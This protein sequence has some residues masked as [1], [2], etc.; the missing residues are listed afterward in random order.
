[1]DKRI[2]VLVSEFVMTPF[3]LPHK[4]ASLADLSDDVKVVK[5]IALIEGSPKKIKQFLE[6]MTSHTKLSIIKLT[7]NEFQE[8]L[9]ERAAMAL[10]SFSGS[11]SGEFLK[12]PGFEDILAKPKYLPEIIDS[13]NE[14]FEKSNFSK[15]MYGYGHINFRKGQGLLLHVRLPVPVEDFY[16]ERKV[17][18][19]RISETVYNVINLLKDKYKISH[20]AEHSPGP[21]QIWLNSKYRESLR[22][23]ITSGEAFH[24]PHLNIIDEL[25]KRKIAPELDKQKELFTEAMYTYLSG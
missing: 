6:I 9:D 11:E 25:L 3:L 19:R 10:L 18:M 22:K 1:L 12:I 24:N 23:D 4:F 2:F 13:I 16:S 21:F 7:E 17:N 8:Y 15:V 5:W 20:K 14:I